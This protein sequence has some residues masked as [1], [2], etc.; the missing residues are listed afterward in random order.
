VAVGQPPQGLFHPGPVL[1]LNPPQRVGIDAVEQRMQR[2]AV[3]APVVVHPS[4]DDRIDHPG[5]I[6]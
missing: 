1:L 4:P 2:R 5:Q 6:G 3:E